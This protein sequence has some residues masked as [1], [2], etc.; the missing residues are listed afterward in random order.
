MTNIQAINKSEEIPTN[1]Q[2]V[3]LGWE[4]VGRGD[5]EVLA[6]DY[7]DDMVFIMPGQEDVLEGKAAFRNALDN[8]AAAL[9]PG[10]NI[11]GV[12][13]IG[14]HDE[15]VSI[16]DW[17]SDKVPQGSQ[18]AVLFRFE[19]SKIFEERWFT[20]TEQWRAAF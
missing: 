3:A 10:F 1:A 15:I 8:L 2:I 16:V 9:P 17:T 7:V 11:T 12:R 6:A 20:D 19:Q 14:E 4:A 13:Q 18:T 5:W